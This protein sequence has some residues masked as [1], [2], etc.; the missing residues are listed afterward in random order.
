[1]AF[2]GNDNLARSFLR[3]VSSG[4]T[5]AHVH[6]EALQLPGEHRRDLALRCQEAVRGAAAA[7]HASALAA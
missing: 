3:V 1:V 7:R 6:V 5:V 2:V 4:P